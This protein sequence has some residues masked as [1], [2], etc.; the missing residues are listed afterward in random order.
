MGL[1]EWTDF[2]NLLARIIVIQNLSLSQGQLVSTKLYS[3]VAY[4]SY[5]E[6]LAR[7][8]TTKPKSKVSTRTIWTSKD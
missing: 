3:R 2:I 7:R 6:Q 8:R 4:F 1:N 5:Q